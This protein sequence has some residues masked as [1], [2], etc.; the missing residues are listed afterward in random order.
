MA[1]TNQVNLEKINQIAQERTRKKKVEFMLMQELSRAYYPYPLDALDKEFKSKWAEE[2]KSAFNLLYERDWYHHPQIKELIG[3]E[4]Y[5]KFCDTAAKYTAD[6]DIYVAEQMNSAKLGKSYLEGKIDKEAVLQIVKQERR[7]GN[8][9]S[10]PAVLNLTKEEWDEFLFSNYGEYYK[11]RFF[12]IELEENPLF[13]TKIESVLKYISPSFDSNDIV[14]ID[15]KN[16]KENQIKR[17]IAQK[18]LLLE[19]IEQLYTTGMLNELFDLTFEKVKEINELLSSDN[20]IEVVKMKENGKEIDYESSYKLFKERIENL[21]VENQDD[22]IELIML[23]REMLNKYAKNI[24]EYESNILNMYINPEFLRKREELRGRLSQE[25]ESNFIKTREAFIRDI[26]DTLL[27]TAFLS[28]DN[29]LNGEEFTGLK[30]E[31]QRKLKK[32]WNNSPKGDPRPIT[33]IRKTRIISAIKY[34]KMSFEYCGKKVILKN[35]NRKNLEENLKTLCENGDG[36]GVSSKIWDDVRNSISYSESIIENLL[37]NDFN[38]SDELYKVRNDYEELPK[39]RDNSNTYE[40]F[41]T[42]I[43]RY[44]EYFKENPNG[45]IEDFIENYLGIADEHYIGLYKKVCDSFSDKLTKIRTIPYE[46]DSDVLVKTMSKFLERKQKIYN[47]KSLNA[48]QLLK[49]GKNMVFFLNKSAN[50]SAINIGIDGYMELFGTHYPQGSPEE[51][52]ENI[53]QQC[54]QSLND[55][56]NSE[57]GKVYIPFPRLTEAQKRELNELLKRND[58]DSVLKVQVVLGTGVDK[59]REEFVQ[60]YETENNHENVLLENEALRNEIETLKATI[61][62]KDKLIEVQGQTIDKFKEKSSFMM[63]FIRTV[64]ESKIGKIFFRKAIKQLPEGTSAEVEEE[65]DDR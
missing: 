53:V 47:L 28:D 27:N 29:A 24:E 9:I 5:Y 25:L 11:N 39:G 26:K 19:V 22:R 13:N 43:E 10:P 3:E 16:D 59:F 41:E 8:Y 52:Y 58:L 1:Q 46:I 14:T 20:Q 51:K 33:D 17:L 45:S 34:Y 63:D 36:K 38:I 60:E 61:A 15:E 4:E 31:I 48:I 30:G 65:R 6:Y 54:P 64:K 32:E 50:G 40:N 21:N 55:I 49:H 23:S 57:N 42:F 2:V 62:A 37:Q 12:E 18:E 35:S 56:Y 7:N 44:F